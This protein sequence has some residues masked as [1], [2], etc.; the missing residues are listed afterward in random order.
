MGRESKSLVLLIWAFNIPVDPEPILVMTG[1][2]VPKSEPSDR[3]GMGAR[4][5]GKRHISDSISFMR[6]RLCLFVASTRNQSHRLRDEPPVILLREIMSRIPDHAY[7][8]V[9]VE[10]PRHG[11]RLFSAQE[12]LLTDQHHASG[13]EVPHLRPPPTTMLEPGVRDHHPDAMPYGVDLI[14]DTDMVRYEAVQISRERFFCAGLLL[15][16]VADG[17]AGVTV[18]RLVRCGNAVVRLQRTVP[19]HV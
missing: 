19:S 17:L 9:F 8:D 18:A 14:L 1:H 6:K 7:I 10:L 12:A 11:I 4:G 13:P 15:V 5:G 16:D 3:V 2:L